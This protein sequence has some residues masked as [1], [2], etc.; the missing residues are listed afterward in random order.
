MLLNCDARE[1]SWESLGLQ[2]DQINKS[3]EKNQRC[4]FIGKTDAETEAPIF[5]PLDAKN[6]LIG[7]D[8]DTGRIK[9][10][11]RRGWQRMRWLDSITDS[12]DINLNK[13]WEIVK[14]REAW[15]AAVHGFTKSQTRLCDW[16]TTIPWK[17]Q[18]N[19]LANS[20]F[21]SIIYFGSCN[22]DKLP[23]KF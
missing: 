19:T 1:D 22:L 14:D 6:R 2:G 15:C 3:K 10:R 23:Y 12:M 21:R 17:S 8:P 9:G 5:W 13:L 4:I 20:T 11:R 18:M 16:T 7:K